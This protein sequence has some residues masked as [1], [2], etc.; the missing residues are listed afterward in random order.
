LKEYDN[1]TFCWCTTLLS[2]LQQRIQNYKE[3]ISFYHHLAFFGFLWQALFVFAHVL[4]HQ[5]V[6][7]SCH[8]NFQ[9]EDL[10]YRNRRKRILKSQIMMDMQKQRRTFF[11]RRCI[12]IEQKKQK[13]KR[14]F[15]SFFDLN[16]PSLIV[17]RYKS[18]ED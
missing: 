3:E 11:T 4:M 18:M 9:P 12:H 13:T 15:W 14:I 16:K 1:Y 7:H 5:W 17:Q 8:R 2:L 10:R 6:D